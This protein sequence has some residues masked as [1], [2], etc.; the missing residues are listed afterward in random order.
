[1]S[2][3]KSSTKIASKPQTKSLKR[4]KRSTI[5]NFVK[6]FRRLGYA[7][8]GMLGENH[9]AGIT[10]YSK[11]AHRMIEIQFTGKVRF[12]G[13]FVV[14]DYIR[15]KALKFKTLDELTRCMTWASQL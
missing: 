6:T 4:L 12:C 7:D 9:D 2:T 1:M 15:A 14:I 10:C 13:K 5:T 8:F 3:T 11:K